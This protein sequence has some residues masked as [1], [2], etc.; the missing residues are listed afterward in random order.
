MT[1]CAKLRLNLHTFILNI[2]TYILFIFI[3][4]VPPAAK[5]L[6]VREE[7]LVLL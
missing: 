4:R 3:L 6:E 5:V 1:L 2:F 7:K